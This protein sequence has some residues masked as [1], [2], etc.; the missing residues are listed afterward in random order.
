MTSL[1]LV[2][3]E[4]WLDPHGWA[5]VPAVRQPVLY[6]NRNAEAS[7]LIDEIDERWATQWRWNALYDKRWK[8]HTYARRCCS[9]VNPFTQQRENRTIW[10]HRE[11]LARMGPPPSS[12]HTLGDHLNGNTLDN[13]RANLRWATPS[14]NNKNRLGFVL[15]PQYHFHEY[16]K[17]TSK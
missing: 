15:V 17:G 14:Q 7:C 16:L 5:G 11:I 9:V 4:D 2:E 12:K 13:R 10:L 8:K 3:E 6:L 1:L